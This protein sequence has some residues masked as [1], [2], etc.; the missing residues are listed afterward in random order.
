MKKIFLALFLIAVA[1]GVSAEELSEEKLAG[2]R[3]EAD[4]FC[5][6]TSDL[7]P[8]RVKCVEGYV[9]SKIEEFDLNN[10]H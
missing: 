5:E 1:G 8:D 2:I 3:A 4:V 6:E 9:N 7:G 10:K